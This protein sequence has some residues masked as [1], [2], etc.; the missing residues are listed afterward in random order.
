MR[1]IDSSIYRVL[2][3]YGKAFPNMRRV[4]SV[5]YVCPQGSYET[6]NGTLRYA[7]QAGTAAIIGNVL[8]TLPNIL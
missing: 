6:L 7:K 3:R 8:G 5:N 2:R 1:R 4:S